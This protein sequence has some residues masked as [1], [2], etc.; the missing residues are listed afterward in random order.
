M[1]HVVVIFDESDTINLQVYGIPLIERLVRQ[2]GEQHVDFIWI[3][4]DE[5]SSLP[6]IQAKQSYRILS[7]RDVPEAISET[8]GP[9]A[10]YFVASNTVVDDRL[11]AFLM[12]SHENTQVRLPVDT[13]PLIVRLDGNTVRQSGAQ[14]GT[15]AGLT[16]LIRTTPAIV[17]KTP[18]D[19]DAYIDDLRLRNEPYL[20][21]WR[22]GD[23]M[24][25]IENR[26]YEANF[27]GT[28]D[29]IAIYI[30]KYPV[31]EI[32]RLLGRF[33]WVSPNHLTFLSI[34]A[35]FAVPSFFAAGHLGWAILIGWL[36]FILDSVDGKLAR[37]TVR[38][39]KTAG[40]LEHATST[41]ALFLWFPSLGWHLSDGGLLDFSQPV[42]IAMW[43]LMLLYW[44]DKSIN[45]LFRRHFKIDLYNWSRFDEKF[46]LIA[47]R[48]A[49][50]MLIITIGYMAGNVEAGFVALAG[51]MILTFVIH[52]LRFAMI[53]IGHRRS[54]AVRQHD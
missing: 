39:S 21:R 11:I 7:P 9:S 15:S 31:R 36:M 2:A 28:L 8:A 26:M 38:L 42:V 6:D 37:L 22:A 46:H 18:A 49:I 33:R 14:L 53:L 30:Y 3:V 34:V 20:F 47:C 52:A 25:P 44:L 51:W 23:A 19:F 1:K 16:D 45:G 12:Q 41:P 40:L 54:S 17:T 48:R 4:T 32:V 13:A 10:F 50:I 43:I 24:R 29:F 5:P 27:K 35:S